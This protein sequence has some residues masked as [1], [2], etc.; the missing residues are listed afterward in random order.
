MLCDGKELSQEVD[1]K[2]RDGQFL[3]KVSQKMM[4]RPNK[5]QTKNERYLRVVQQMMCCELKQNT[6]HN[7]KKTSFLFQ[8]FKKVRGCMDFMKQ[9][10]FCLVINLM[11]RRFDSKTNFSRVHLFYKLRNSCIKTNL[12]K[13]WFENVPDSEL[14]IVR[15]VLSFSLFLY[16]KMNTYIGKYIQ[17]VREC[18]IVHRETIRR[19][20]SWVCGRPVNDHTSQVIYNFFSLLVWLEDIF[21]S[22]NVSVFLIVA[23]PLALVKGLPYCLFSM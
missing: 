23:V 3:T 20:D 21:I 17:T 8:S 16:T 12:Q 6:L 4:K 5:I 13:C 18:K 14:I 2:C 22:V 15:C 7:L 9:Y 10:I 1:I 11:E 19:Y